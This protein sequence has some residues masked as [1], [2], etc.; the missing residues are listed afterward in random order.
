VGPKLPCL[1][2]YEFE[3]AVEK[4][5]AYSEHGQGHADGQNPRMLKAE[6]GASKQQKP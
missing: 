2:A 3:L 6:E 5:V 4:G 1:L